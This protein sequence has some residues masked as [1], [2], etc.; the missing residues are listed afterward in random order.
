MTKA[1]WSVG[2]CLYFKFYVE[3]IVKSFI[4]EEAPCETKGWLVKCVDLVKPNMLPEC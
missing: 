3:K 4:P 1:D 2:I